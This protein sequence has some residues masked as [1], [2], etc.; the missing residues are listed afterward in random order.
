[1]KEKYPICLTCYSVMVGVERNH[2]TE[3][4]YYCPVCKNY[5]GLTEVWGFD[6]VANRIRAIAK[7]YNINPIHAVGGDDE[8]E[9]T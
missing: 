5:K 6:S 9:R 8:Y 2:E 7:E 1:M 3:C 4:R